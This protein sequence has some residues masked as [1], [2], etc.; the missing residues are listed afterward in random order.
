[1][2]LS[3]ILFYLFYKK[4]DGRTDVYDVYKKYMKAYLKNEFYESENLFSK[5]TTSEI[6]SDMRM[7]VRNHHIKSKKEFEMDK[8]ALEGKMYGETY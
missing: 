5:K 4:H 6:I 7:Q 3:E 2:L 1:M 8:Y